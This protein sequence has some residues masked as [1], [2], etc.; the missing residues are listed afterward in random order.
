MRYVSLRWLRIL[1]PVNWLT[2]LRAGAGFGCLEYLH[3]RES[4]N[5]TLTS[6]TNLNSKFSK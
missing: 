2:V 5:L 3:R 1:V 4:N 6:Q